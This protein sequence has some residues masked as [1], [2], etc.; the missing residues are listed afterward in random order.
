M[1]ATGLSIPEYYSPRANGSPYESC[2]WVTRDIAIKDATGKATFEQE[3]CH[4]PAHFSPLSCQIVA[5]KYFR[6]KVGTPE[7]EASLR[8]VIDRVVQRIVDWGARGGYF[9]T[10]RDEGN[11]ARELA[12]LLLH[13]YASFN[14]PVW[15][16]L[17][18]PG[19]EQQASAC[20]ILRAEDTLEDWFRLAHEEGR[21][22]KRGSG[23]GMNLSRIRSS[24]DWLSGGGRPSG[25]LSLMAILDTGAGQIKSGGVTRRAAKMHVLDVTH[26]D[27]LQTREGL[28]GFVWC[29]LDQEKA[30]QALI[31]G[32][33]DGGFNVP[34]GAYSRVCYQNANHSVRAS[35]AF[36]HAVEQGWEWELL[37]RQGAPVHV[38][39]AREILRQIAEAAHA[40]GDPGLQLATRSTPGTRSRT[41]ARLKRATHAANTSR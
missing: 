6:G 5:G 12:Y 33:F 7:R 10:G 41:P 28:P 14:S 8:Q 3:G 23:S 39:P 2:E 36:M 29:K 31:A 24:W 17:G 40:C 27:L 30:A 20:F 13:Q 32:G 15:F 4:F 21:I 9:K 11:F 22:F 16:N 35:D 34:G 26:P 37:D 25:P 38:L 18:V 1:N 19:V